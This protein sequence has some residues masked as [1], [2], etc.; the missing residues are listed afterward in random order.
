MKIVIPILTF[1]L[2]STISVGQNKCLPSY[3]LPI[4]T[5]QLS[6]GNLAY[7]E[8]GNGQTILFIHGLGGNISHWLKS[9]E[10]LSK[11]YQCIA[12]DLP[13]YG[14]SDNNVDKTN[15]DKLQ[16][17][18][19]V[20]KEFIVQKKLKKLVII[21][22]SMGGQ[23]AV[24]TAL[25]DKNIEKLVLVTPAGF[26]TFT[27]SE[28]NFLINATPA[29][30]FE[31]QD[32]NVIRN[33]FKSNFVQQPTDIEQLIQYRLDIRTCDHFKA[34][35]ETVSSGIK[36]MLNHPIKDSLSHLKL[37][38][39]LV[40]GAND[41]LI[42]NRFLHPNLKTDELFKQVSNLIQNCKIEMIPQT[43]HMVQ[44]ENNSSINQLIRDFIR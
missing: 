36:G 22:H 27:E 7:V 8:K 43:G 5:T 23:I 33:N 1:I 41:L 9:V 21:G 12:I 14:W 37:P 32:E 18:V 39:L 25:Q 17:Y 6:F 15:I 16:F 31:K 26:E 3:D 20:I 19:D 24:I 2:Y 30:Y 34:Y 35:C 38:V 11:Q 28:G 10:E 44:F 4:K 42:P 13:G 40:Y 29:S